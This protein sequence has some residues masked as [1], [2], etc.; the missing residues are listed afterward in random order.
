MQ[1][2]TD[3]LKKY[4]KLLGLRIRK[5]RLSKGLSLRDL[6]RIS[7]LEKPNLSRI[8]NGRANITFRTAI[9]LSVALDI[10]LK[11]LFDISLEEIKKEI[12]K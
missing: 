11:D 2:E 4:Y 5:F 1:A 12:G 3:I 8:E 10:E 7:D 9:I 6:A